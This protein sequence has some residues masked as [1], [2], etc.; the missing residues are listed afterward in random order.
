[1]FVLG[2]VVVRVDPVAEGLGAE[3]VE[4]GIA[5]VAAPLEGDG[6][7]DDASEMLGGREWP[8]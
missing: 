5:D 6:H 7:V 2:V 3:G 8:R 1:M 4:F